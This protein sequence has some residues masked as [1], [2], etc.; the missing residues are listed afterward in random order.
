M[1]HNNSP[2][3][4]FHT[5]LDFE[6]AEIT[7]EAAMTKDQTNCLL[8]LVHHFASGSDMFTLQDHD[9]VCSL[10]DLAFQCYT[11]VSVVLTS[12]YHSHCKLIISAQFQN[13]KVSVPLGNQTQI[14]HPLP[15]SLGL[16]A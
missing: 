1:P 2:W 4:P 15:P 3:E 12:N 9:E 7:L 10:W 5:Q 13:N 11:R 16:G 14:Q 6:I 8:K